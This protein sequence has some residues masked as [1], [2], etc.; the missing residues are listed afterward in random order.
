MGMM[1]PVIFFRFKDAKARVISR[2]MEIVHVSFE[3][4]HCVGSV[5]LFL[6]VFLSP[7]PFEPDGSVQ[8]YR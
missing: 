5:S 8:Q 4:A 7:D 2:T 1:I 3:Y 6:P